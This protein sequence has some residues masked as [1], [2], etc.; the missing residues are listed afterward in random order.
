MEASDYIHQRMNDVLK[1]CGG[2]RRYAIYQGKLVR[3]ELLD[4]N[5][6]AAW[7]VTQDRLN[8]KTFKGTIRLV[9][10]KPNE[11]VYISDFDLEQKAWTDFVRLQSIPTE[12]TVEKKGGW[13]IELPFDPFPSSLCGSINDKNKLAAYSAANLSPSPTPTG[14]QTEPPVKASDNYNPD[15]NANTE[16]HT[17]SL[18]DESPE[19]RHTD[20]PDDSSRRLNTITLDIDPSTGLIAAPT[21]PVIRSKS[22]YSGQQPTEH[23]GPEHHQPTPDDETI[24]ANVEDLITKD[25]YLAVPLMLAKFA[26]RNGEVTVIGILPDDDHKRYA[27]RLIRTVPGVRAVNIKEP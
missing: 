20:D 9:S 13:V 27:E 5:T 18:P 4:W 24:R 11:Q 6:E 12:I 15:Q 26:V 17:E 23:C 1:K 14:E 19:Q 7:L 22:F 21:C 2:G 8:G 25:G 16:K 3:F 10:A